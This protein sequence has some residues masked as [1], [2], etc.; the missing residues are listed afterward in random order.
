MCMEFAH[1]KNK[2]PPT[3]N[4]IKPKSSHGSKTRNP[5]RNP[6]RNSKNTCLANMYRNPRKEILNTLNGT[7]QMK[8]KKQNIHN[9]KEKTKEIYYNKSLNITSLKGSENISITGIEIKLRLPKR[10]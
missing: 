9:T 2:I 3:G 6:N 10:K 7:H 5:I 1:Y 8:S 4:G